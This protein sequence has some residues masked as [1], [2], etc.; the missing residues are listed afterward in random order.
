MHTTSPTL[1]ERLR[2]PEQTEAWARFVQ[3]YSPL[4]YYW[5]RRTGLQPEDAADLVQEVFAVLLQKLPQFEYD[6]QRSFRG[7]L[8]VVTLNKWKEARRRHAARTTAETDLDEVTAHKE[9]D[10]L[11]DQ[12]YRQY[13]VARALEL[14]KAEFQPATWQACWAHIVEGKSAAEVA[15]ELRMSANAVYLATSRVLRRLRTELAGLWD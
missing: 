4:I 9:A 15:T 12:E 13:L 2:Q 5:S 14:M 7:W 6:G 11:W 3:L 1:L 8:R 10:A